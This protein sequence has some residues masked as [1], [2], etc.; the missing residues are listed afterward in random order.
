MA[1][2]LCSRS[3]PSAF[4][5]AIMG[6]SPGSSFAMVG[7]CGIAPKSQGVASS[8]RPRSFSGRRCAAASASNPPMQ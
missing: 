8:P 3:T 5:G 1:K 7:A 6:S 4:I 2:R